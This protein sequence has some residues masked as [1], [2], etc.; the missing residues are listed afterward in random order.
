MDPCNN[1]DHDHPARTRPD[2]V[3]QNRISYG[4]GDD[5]Q[6][7]SDALSSAA[8][9]PFKKDH[10]PIEHRQKDRGTKNTTGR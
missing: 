8:H 1:H 10:L 4:L 5:G 3:R 6:M 7:R 9:S 2:S